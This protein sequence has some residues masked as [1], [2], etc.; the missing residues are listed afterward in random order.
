MVALSKAAP[1]SSVL[2]AMLLTAA[3]FTPA[4]V[5]AQSVSRVDEA[6]RAGIQ[7]GI[8]PGAVV[9]I[10]RRDSLLYARGYGH[11]TWDPGSPVPVPD[12]TIWDL[13]SI[14]K[15]VS[16][17]SSAMRLVDQGRLNLE[18]PVSTYLPRFSGGLKGRVTVRMLLDHTSGLKSYVPFYQMAHGKAAATRLLYAQPLVHTPGDTAV[19]SDLNAL[20][21]GLIVEKV[22]GTSIDRF[23]AREVFT[24]LGMTQ[25]MFRPEKKL[26]RRIAPSGLWR[27]QPVAGEVN[28]Q[29]AVMFGGIAGHAGVFSTAADLARFAQVWL[30]AG[31]GPHGQ[32]VSFQTMSRFLSRGA[33]TGSRLL[34]W[35]TRERVAGEPSVFGDLTSDATYGHTGFT[36]TLLWIDP[37]RDLFL[38]FLTNR[39]FDP[40]VPESVKELKAVRAAV[41]DAAVSLVPHGCG[42]ELISKC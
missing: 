8:Y 25:T 3:A 40:R 34:G 30:R 28:D 16:T 10:G 11:F 6:V 17:M 27:G 26:R 22:A 35:D 14:T 15:I 18:A 29:N 5:D 42:Q 33:N 38:I 37:A 2:L 41:S 32:W 23:A 36:G 1:H 39:T 9:I 12:S 7:R 20:L 13:A 19:Y 24:P 4:V 31:A 21:L